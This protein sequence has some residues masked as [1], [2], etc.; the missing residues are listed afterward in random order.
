MPAELAPQLLAAF[1][2]VIIIVVVVLL[3]FVAFAFVIN[4]CGGCDSSDGDGSDDG[5]GAGDNVIV[6]VAFIVDEVVL[7]TVVNQY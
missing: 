1:I 3:L 5:D 4:G 6:F 2:V 7:E